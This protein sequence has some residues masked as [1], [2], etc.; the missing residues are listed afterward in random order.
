MDSEKIG[1]VYNALTGD[2]IA[3]I[4]G[5]N[6]ENVNLASGHA[7]ILTEQT[8]NPTAFKVNIMG[9]NPV[10]EA[11]DVP[12]IDILQTAKNA[13]LVKIDEI[14]ASLRTSIGSQGYGQESVYQIKEEQARAYCTAS[15]PVDA[16]YPVLLAEK[17]ITAD[18]VRGVAEL[19]CQK[20][21]QW[22]AYATAIEAVKLATKKQIRAATT[23]EAI[24]TILDAVSWPQ[25]AN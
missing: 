1:I 14:V 16:D 21:D 4:K 8:I 2:I 7:L 5:V 17:G 3:P 22:R 11:I 6:L 18:T 15:N 23:V 9:P 20:S 25:P 12:E 24:Q 19:I 10:L 13:A